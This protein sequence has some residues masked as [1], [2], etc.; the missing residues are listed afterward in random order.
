MTYY[1]HKKNNDNPVRNEA[2]EKRKKVL[3]EV[4]K[5]RAM[6]RKNSR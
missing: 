4:R 1:P 5:R 2:K 6:S 3:A